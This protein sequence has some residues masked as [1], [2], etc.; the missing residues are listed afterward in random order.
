[1]KA[2]RH[3]VR[4]ALPFENDSFDACY[5]HM[6]FCM[7]LT[8]R[9]LHISAE[10]RRIFAPAAQRLYGPPHRRCAL[11]TASTAPRTCMKWAVVVHFFTREG[12]TPGRRLRARGDR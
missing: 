8:T 5:S 1:V 6:L 4:M 2:V 10:V 9:E 12:R 7:A 3:D 11:R